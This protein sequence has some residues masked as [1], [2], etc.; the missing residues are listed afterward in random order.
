MDSAR[1]VDEVWVY[2]QAGCAAEEA[3]TQELRQAVPGKVFLAAIYAWLGPDDGST[4]D[5]RRIP[6]GG[7][8]LGHCQ[9]GGVSDG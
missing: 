5:N 2:Y 7:P 9:R 4:S 3:L 8:E 6:E 1:P